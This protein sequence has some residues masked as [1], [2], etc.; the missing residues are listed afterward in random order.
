MAMQRLFDGL[1][2]QGIETI[3]YCPRIRNG[4]DHDPLVRAGHDVQRF[5]A[6]VPVFVRGSRDLAVSAPTSGPGGDE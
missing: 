4:A 1:K 2:G 5:N 6:F 3:V